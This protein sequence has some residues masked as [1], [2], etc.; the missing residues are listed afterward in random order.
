MHAF[1]DVLTVVYVWVFCVSLSLP[2]DVDPCRSSPMDEDAQALRLIEEA[3][4]PR[5]LSRMYHGWCPFW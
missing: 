5:N 4:S 2:L 3:T 1:V